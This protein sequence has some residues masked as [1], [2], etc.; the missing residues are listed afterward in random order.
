[1][2]SVESY[3]DAQW[4]LNYNALLL[5]FHQTHVARYFMRQYLSVLKNN[6]N[7]VNST[8]NKP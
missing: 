2:M 6:N 1:M 5:L 3:D 4:T 7:N 8:A